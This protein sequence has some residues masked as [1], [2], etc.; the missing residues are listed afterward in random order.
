MMW[1]L[2]MQ[3]LTQ[4]LM[5][6]L[7]LMLFL[8]QVVKTWK[9]KF[10]LL[11]WMFFFVS[12][13]AVF[14][15]ENFF[16]SQKLRDFSIGIDILLPYSTMHSATV[17]MYIGKSVIIAYCLLNFLSSYLLRVR[18]LLARP[19]YLGPDDQNQQLFRNM[20]EKIVRR[21]PPRHSP[22]QTFTTP[23]VKSDVHHPRRSP[24]PL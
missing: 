24:P 17:P 6:I 18:V 10:A 2:L 8:I 15:I 20:L 7:N 12:V 9:L 23:S 21:S 22:P 5:L 3:I 13:C 14:W 16:F 4:H 1:S 11:G 19:F